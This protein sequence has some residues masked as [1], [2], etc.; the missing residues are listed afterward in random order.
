MAIQFKKIENIVKM[1]FAIK[2]INELESKTFLPLVKLIAPFIGWKKPNLDSFMIFQKDFTAWNRKNND[3]ASK[4]WQCNFML[5]KNI[6]NSKNILVHEEKM[7]IAYSIPDQSIDK[8]HIPYLAPEV[9][10]TKQYTCEADIY[11]LGIVL[12]EIT[13]GLY[14]YHNILNDVNLEIKI[15]NGIRP[16]FPNT[17]PNLISQIIS[18]CWNADPSRRPNIEELKELVQILKI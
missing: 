3:M 14:P 12:Y 8:I 18:H 16:E 15:C 17:T 7:I 1:F 4:L 9:L 2:E 11:S 6:K 5:W 10:R 13:T